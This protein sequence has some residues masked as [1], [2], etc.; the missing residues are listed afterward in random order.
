LSAT[1]SDSGELISGLWC[2]P[3]ASCD[4]LQERYDIHD[5]QSCFYPDFT[6]I[7]DLTPPAEPSA[8]GALTSGTCTRGCACSAGSDPTA[9][10]LGTQAHC[11]MLSEQNVTGLCSISLCEEDSDC[12]IHGGGVCAQHASLPAW[13]AAHYQ[14]VLDRITGRLDPRP[15]PGFCVSKSA[16]DA[17]NAKN[18]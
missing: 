2:M 6:T 17:W 18:H 7:E 10:Y 11:E 14:G 13:A 1:R 12:L 9:E 3:A 5:D 4:V 15:E 16:C 8:C